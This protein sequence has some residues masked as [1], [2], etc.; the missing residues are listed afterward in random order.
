MNAQALQQLST[1]SGTLTISRDTFDAA[2]ADFLTLHYGGGPLVIAQA[3]VKAQE[4]GSLVVSGL[5]SFANVADLPLVARFAI[6]AGGALQAELRYTLRDAAPGPAAWR[7]SHSFPALPTCWDEPSQAYVTPLDQLDLFDTDFV[8]TTHA[9]VDAR[10]GVALQP[11]INIVGCLRPSGL[12]GVFE[13]RTVSNPILALHGIVNLGRPGELTLELLP[14]ER[15]WDRLDHPSTG[16]LA[17]GIYLAAALDLGFSAGKLALRDTALRLYS[18]LTTAWADE[19][20][21]YDVAQALC[22][23]LALPSAA[24]EIRISAD[25]PRGSASTLLIGS[26]SGVTVG[27]LADLLDI[28]GGL[29]AALP[30]ALRGPVEA[31]DELELIG[32]TLDLV[33]SEDLPKLRSASVSVGFPSLRWRVWGDELVVESLA[34]RFDLCDP[35]HLNAAPPPDVP[36]L[37]RSR[38]NVDVTGVLVIEGVPLEVIASSHERFAVRARTLEPV[39]LPLDRVLG[40]HGAGISSP[41]PLAITAFEVFIAPG[42]RYAMDLALAGAPKPWTIELGKQA[43]SVSNVSIQLAKSANGPATGRFAGTLAFEGHVLSLQYDAPGALV[44]RSTLPRIQLSRLI[45]QLCD[46]HVELPSGFDLALRASSI[47]IQVVD[48]CPAVQLMTEVE[49]LGVLAFETRKIGE[50]WGFAFGLDLTTG[51]PSHV[52]GLA[53]LAALEQLLHLQRFMVVVSSLDQPSFQLPSASQFNN[54]VL[55]TKQV[56]LPRG[57]G[58]RAGLNIFADWSL[59]ASDKSQNLLKKL[60]GLE[61][62]L[63]AVIQVPPDPSSGTRLVVQRSGTLLGHRFEYEVGVLLEQGMPAL[64]LVGSVTVPIQ[65]SPVT[66][67]A[68]TLFVPSGAF[69]AA[70]MKNPKPLAIGPVRLSNV[71]LEVGVSWAGIPSLGLVAT[72]DTREFSSSIAVFFDSTNPAKSLVAGSISDVDARQIL[73]ALLPG[74]TTPIDEVL[75]GIAIEGTQAFELPGELAA[76]LDGMQHDKVSA[77]F[78]SSAKLSIPAVAQQLAISPK[79]QGSSWHVTDLTQMRHY[80]LEKQGGMIRGEVAAQFYFAPQATAIGSIVFPQAYYLN[81]ALSFA[82]FEAR[83]TVDIADNKGYSID[84]TIDEIVIL[85]RAIFAITAQKGEGGAQLSLSTF[86]RPEHP[87]VEFRDP[88]VY[89]NGAL[90]LLGLREGVFANITSQGIDFEL[91]GALLPGVKFEV[92]VRFGKRGFAASGTLQVGLGTIDLGTLGKVQINSEIEVGIDI[93]LDDDHRVSPKPSVAA[94]LENARLATGTSFGKNQVLL[95]NGLVRLVFQAD[96]NLVLYTKHGAA[97]WA[98]GTNGKGGSRVDFQADGNLV[99]Y[100][101]KKAVWSSGSHDKGVVTLV[102]QT[103]GNLVLYDGA[104]KAHWDT[105]TNGRVNAADFDDGD[106]GAAHFEDATLALGQGFAP[107]ATLL[108]NGL[109]RLVFQGDG[110]LCLYAASGT[111]LWGTNTAGK[112]AKHVELQSD[113]NLVLRGAANEVLWASGTAGKGVAALV[114]RIDGNLVLV[115]GAHDTKWASNTAGKCTPSE[116]PGITLEAN[117]VLAGQPIDLGK[118]HIA[119]TPDA[120]ARVPKIV[121]KKLEKALRGVFADVD[122]WANALRAGV[123]DGVHD[124]QK[125]LREVYGKSEKDAE[126]LAKDVEKGLAS[127]GK[128]VSHAEKSVEKAAKKTIKKVKFW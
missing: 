66:F 74:V 102:A 52:A 14:D 29:H 3:E 121:E 10:S 98:S 41:T 64:F 50:Q 109:A 112:A 32:V 86:A 33:V 65:S 110:N 126:A 4:D 78:A 15:P 124:T 7:F 23:V 125:V 113:G 34:C 73:R 104:G 8:V 87:V 79:K 128:A 5:S 9:G 44:I 116:G 53:Q 97:L 117:V 111:Y 94:K 103:D 119:L 118:F 106:D 39:E 49:G 27:K 85:D 88:H 47:V 89:I 58:V 56:A 77:A 43:L 36:P 95:D 93:D 72:I 67:D 63:E 40:S 114:L 90:V 26:C 20:R 84:A 71:A 24:V 18:P 76:A 17:P 61:G 55:A 62:N 48:G 91:V 60:L 54:P 19:N 75:A 35:L 2:F 81:V 25:M 21:S 16:A 115:D 57:G 13:H 101:G 31:L 122:K 123:M 45:A 99:I 83:A 46:R 69:M 59:D 107:G 96:G 22:G 6:A 1:S 12:L 37:F 42:Q 105:N 100:D 28:G 68:T 38:V 82:G 127:A 30:A 108:D 120:L 11:G 70:T 92:D 51:Q 80:Q